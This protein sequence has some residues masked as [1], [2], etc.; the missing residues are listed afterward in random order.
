LN[1]HTHFDNDIVLIAAREG[2]GKKEQRGKRVSMIK[3]ERSK[4]SGWA[5]DLSRVC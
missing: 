4:K 2:A 1:S 3:T 5:I